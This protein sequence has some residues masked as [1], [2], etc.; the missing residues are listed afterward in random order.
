MRSALTRIAPALRGMGIEIHVS[1]QRTR[2]GRI[3]TLVFRKQGA[4]TVTTVTPSPNPPDAAKNAVS[5]DDA[6]TVGDGLVTVG[7][8]QPSPEDTLF[9][10]LE[11]IGDGGDGCDGSGA[12]SS[13]Q[14][15][16]VFEL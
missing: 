3:I 16:E 13:N 15:R 7:A 8:D 5:K 9:G 14:Q 1:D 11:P 6:V 12:Q 2:K 4:E 10:P